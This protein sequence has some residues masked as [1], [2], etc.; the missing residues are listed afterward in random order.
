MKK[1][2]VLFILLGNRHKAS[3]RVR[4]FWVADELARFGIKSSIVFGEDRASFFRYLFKL[5]WYDILYIQKRCSRWDYYL[6]RV[7]G[8]L[9]K[10]TIFDID[11]AYSNVKSKKT[12]SNIQRI[13]KNAS[14]ITVG[15]RNLFKFAKKYQEKIYF[16]P[17]SIKIENYKMPVEKKEQPEICLGWI[18][19]G[20]HYFHDLV[21]ILKEP[22]L[23]IASQ[24][25]IRF[26]L[27]GACNQQKLYQAFSNT[28]G[29]NITFIDE[30]DW[31]DP[32]E[33]RKAMLDFDIGLY[34]L[35]GN[36]SNQ[37]K[38]GFKALEYMALGIPV[39]TSPIG[40]NCYI[41]TNGTDGF[42][43]EGNEE[44]IDALTILIS[45]S[46]KRKRMGQAGRQKVEAQYSIQEYTKKLMEIMFK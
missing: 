14:A 46:A 35:L 16:L 32:D 21:E 13:M 41:V 10:R 37:Y 9:G 24:Y 1:S 20:A 15:S 18:G 2:K 29:L 39:V 31:G 7:A 23:K 28:P 3:S 45:D 34:P 22:F 42:H 17:S 44:W 36:Y 38:C 8:Y 40:A 5:P 12:L 6:L 26:K 43:A 27:V 30:I 11:D 33:V 19:N 25:R 4:G